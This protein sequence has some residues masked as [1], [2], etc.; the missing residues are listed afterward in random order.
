[1]KGKFTKREVVLF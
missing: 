1:M